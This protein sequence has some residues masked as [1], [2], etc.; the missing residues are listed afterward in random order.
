MYFPAPIASFCHLTASPNLP[1]SAWAA[2]RVERWPASFH[3]DSS[4]DRQDP[5]FAPPVLQLDGPDRTQPADAAA[6]GL[7]GVFLGGIIGGVRGNIS[8]KGD[9]GGLA[10]YQGVTWGGC[11]GAL[12]GMA[13][14]VI[15]VLIASASLQS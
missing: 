8:A 5:A 11:L 2:A 12:I 14:A 15:L 1:A 6:R 4:H 3:P 10:T 13:F 7:L 9:D